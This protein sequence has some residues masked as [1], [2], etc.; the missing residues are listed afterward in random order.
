MNSSLTIMFRQLSYPFKRYH[1]IILCIEWILVQ[2]LLWHFHGTRTIEDSWKYLRHDFLVVWTIPGSDKMY[3][4]YVG[5]LDICQILGLSLDSIVLIQIIISGLS[6][7][8]LYKIIF[9][10]SNSKS[11]ALLGTGFYILFTKLQIWNYFILTDSIFISLTI[12]TTYVLISRTKP[13][14]KIL[15]V[16]LTTIIRPTGIIFLLAVIVFFFLPIVKE[17]KKAQLKWMVV[18]IGITSFLIVLNQ[19]LIDFRILETWYS[20][21]IVFNVDNY[22]DKEIV[23]QLI[24]DNTHVV[25]CNGQETGEI[26]LFSMLCSILKNPGFTTRLF[27]SKISYFILDIRPYFSNIHKFISISVLLVLYSGVLLY[28]R[29]SSNYPFNIFAFTYIACTVLMAGMT[30]LSWEGRFFAPL[31]PFLI[32]LGFTGYTQ[33]F[34]TEMP[35][36]KIFRKE[37]G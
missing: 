9:E 30:I 20:G 17:I 12:F 1:V 13:I 25:P 32:I 21:K 29:D 6:T 22:K 23:E 14:F 10:L 15:A 36:K 3:S 27:V 31:Y 2:V 37:I 16:A 18:L 24:V 19:L 4:G 28:I 5:F 35:R 11:S 7:V 26:P 34:N 33:F 8:F